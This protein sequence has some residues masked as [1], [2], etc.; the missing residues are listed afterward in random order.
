MKRE[1]TRIAVLRV[2]TNGEYCSERC[3]HSVLKHWCRL[4]YRALTFDGW[5]RRRCNPFLRGVR[6]PAWKDEVPRA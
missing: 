1:R 3:R 6:A 5:G 2:V 4:F